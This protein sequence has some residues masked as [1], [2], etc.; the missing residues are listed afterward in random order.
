[1]CTRISVMVVPISVQIYVMAVC[2][3]VQINFCYGGVYVQY[4]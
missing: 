3:Y 2:K 1:M 4:V